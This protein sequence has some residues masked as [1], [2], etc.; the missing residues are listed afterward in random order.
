V[1]WRRAF[2][3]A[4]VSWAGVLL[5]A[6]FAASRPS[7][8]AVVFGFAYSAYAIGRSV[9]HQLPSRSFQLWSTPLPVCARCMGMYAGAAIAAVVFAARRA[10][11]RSAM[12]G[13]SRV[14]AVLAAAIMPTAATL[15]Y[16]WITGDM[17]AHWIRALA[18]APIGAAVAWIIREVN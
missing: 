4:A 7:G 14:R 8:G 11:A 10:R 15:L 6:P 9:C 16:E 5:L 13:P 12:P 2:V 1:W 3:A 18:G 17:P